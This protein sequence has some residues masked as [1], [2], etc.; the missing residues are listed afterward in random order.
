MP[1]VW[2]YYSKLKNFRACSRNSCTFYGCSNRPK[3]VATK[4]EICLSFF[5]RD[6]NRALSSAGVYSDT[7]FTSRLGMSCSILSYISRLM[8]LFLMAV[9]RSLKLQSMALKL[10][11]SG[12]SYIYGSRVIMTEAETNLWSVKSFSYISLVSKILKKIYCE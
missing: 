1:W 7:E 5:T 6:S 3:I 2:V 9:K 10:L 11:N 4:I 12:L 8:M